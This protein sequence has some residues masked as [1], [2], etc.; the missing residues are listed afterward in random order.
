MFA[1]YFVDH[2]IFANV[3][4]ILTMVIGGLCIFRLP[5]ELYPQITPP[6]IQ[7]STT[8]PGADSQVLA[9]TVAAP[10]EQQVNGVE[11]MMYMSSNCANDGSYGLTVTFEVGTDL[12]MAQVLVQNRV[13]IAMPQLPPDVQ[14]QGITTKKQ[15]TAITMFV[16]FFAKD[17]EYEKIY[18]KTYLANFAGIRIRDELNRLPG[19]GD[20]FVIPGRDYSM[21][22]WLDA[23]K[24]Q[25]H[26]L[27]TQDV[28][29]AIQEQN[30]Q[31]PAGQVGQPPSDQERNFQFTVRVKGRLVE[32]RE[33]EEIV[34]KNTAGGGSGLTRLKDVARVELGGKNYDSYF[35][36]SGAL[37]NLALEE[38]GKATPDTDIR[39]DAKPVAGIAVFMLPGANALEV[40]KVVKE[41]MKELKKTFPPGLDYNIPLDITSYIEVSIHEVYKTLW[42]AGFLVLLVIL[43]FLQ[44]FRAVLVP[45]TTVPVTIMGAFAAMAALG[46]T[47]NMLT[48]FGLVLTIGIV[49]DDAIVVV[50]GA[51]HGVERG[52]TPRDATIKAMDELTGPIIGITLVLMS[53][54]LPTIFLGGITGQIYQQ[55]ALTIAATAVISAINA[56]TLK[57]VQCAQWLRKHPEHPGLFSRTLNA[58]FCNPFNYVYNKCEELY[59]QTIKRLIR[60]SPLA[61]LAFAG[62]IT[63][64]LWLY[65]SLPTGFL[66]IEDQGYVFIGVQLP[67]GASQER[68]REVMDK[69]RGLVLSTDGVDNM[70]QVG[71]QAYDGTIASNVGRCFIRFKHWDLRKDPSQSM[72]AIIGELRK[73]FAAIQEAD[74]FV[75][76]PPAIRG[77]GATGGFQMQVLDRGGVGGRELQTAT[78]NLIAE[79]KKEPVLN[80]K[81]VRTTYRAEVPQVFVDVDR[82]KAKTMDLPLSTVFNTLQAYTGTAYVNDFNK[83]GRTFQVRV[84]ADERF[85]KDAEQIKHL[86][87]RNSAGGM[88]PLGTL[89]NVKQT[90]GPG[91]ITRYNMYQTAALIGDPAAG[92]SSGEALL[93]MERL[94]DSLPPSIGYEWTGMSYQE[95]RASGQAL[96]VF[97]M[98]VLLV[99]LVLAAQYESWTLPAAVIF[100]VPLGLLGSAL[101]VALRGMDNN[102]Y[103]QVGVVLIIALACKNAILI[104]E[105][106]RQLHETGVSIAEAA[107][108]A[109]RRR[110][111]PILMTSFAFILGVYPLVNA[112]GAGAAGRR[113]LGTAVFGGMLASTILAVGFV[114]VFY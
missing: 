105:Y 40:A 112:H 24:L 22:V 108:Q 79:A 104:V 27:T 20:M 2:P 32:P 7:V 62:L 59:Y 12:N 114:P 45:A 25:A 4:A 38:Q 113:A 43:I 36:V 80:E 41:K 61:M 70:S 91:V 66:P 58:V 53:V 98:A 34:I 39:L 60:F 65:L 107:A 97:G 23:E 29:N 37:R 42:E 8:Y 84:Q 103:T 54:F 48:M 82:T 89:V 99:Y 95:R 44:D 75:M 110:F 35:L 86:Q 1:R 52:M 10:I 9:D 74:V 90:T 47:V 78:E 56:M 3:I 81:S 64:A 15:S 33:F 16:T 18:D 28:L 72:D 76:V 50:E 46:F 68:T 87:A 67:D 19:V 94:A 6:T 51:A 71:G 26:G 93:T 63:F 30:I 92:H 49:V 101:A 85:R 13:A 102:M 111:R 100:V 55:F 83:F 17:K 88:V 57:P 96:F 77:L 109:S 31:V 5:A 106:A 11:G 73:K 14:R 69:I 21:R